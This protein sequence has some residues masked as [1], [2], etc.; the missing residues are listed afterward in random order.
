[1][2]S[3]VDKKECIESVECPQIYTETELASA[4][5]FVELGVLCVTRESQARRFS[6][7]VLITLNSRGRKSMS[8]ASSRVISSHT[9]GK[10]WKK[11]YK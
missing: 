7:V 10:F 6:E 8:S 5:L 1:M 3:F 9:P 4:E 2:L 11:A